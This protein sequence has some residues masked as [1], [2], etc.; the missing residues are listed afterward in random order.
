MYDAIIIG[1]GIGGLTAA[2][3]LAKNGLKVLIL[4]KIHH[5]GG[6]SYIFKRKGYTFPQ[7]PLSFSFP[8]IVQD[9]LRDTGI[10]EKISFERNHFQLIS[11]EIDIVYSQNLRDF[12]EELISRFPA[13][14]EGL[15]KFFNELLSLVEVIADI[16][17]WH[18]DYLIGKE[19]EIAQQKLNSH[20]EQL[21]LVEKYDK[22]SSKDLLDKYLHNQ[23]LKKLL[24]S[25][26]TYEPIMSMV[27]LAFMWNVM[28]QVGI[29]FPSCGI[30]GI[31]DLLSERYRA[32]GGE[33]QL[34]TPVKEILIEQNRVKG[35]RTEGGDIFETSWVIA[36]ADY[37]KV[38]LEMILPT[39]LSATFRESVANTPYTGSE[40]CLYLGIDPK[41]VD[42]SRM[43]ANHLFYRFK[44]EH[45]LKSPEAFEN[46]E[47]EICLW[48]N[49]S[50]EFTPIGQKSLVVRANMPY[51]L[52]DPWRIGEKKRKEGYKA[53][54]EQLADKLISVAEEVLPGL[55]DSVVVQDIATPLTYKDWGQRT[56]GSIAGWGRDIKKVRIHTKLLMKDPIDH[57][58][59]VGI[60]SVLEPFL[61]GFP[62]SMYTGNLA[63][64]FVLET[65][66]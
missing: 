46:K 49:K 65:I 42:L 15:K 51:D 5:I 55:S 56:D 54:K 10:T 27:H 21:Q 50:P 28:S 53:Y 25:Q 64:N 7:G 16:H 60:Y 62:V 61:G 8:S 63:A 34:R 59:V 57:L 43:R 23:S 9:I 14:E 1:A 47:I 52:F 19:R 4:E 66:L 13:E 39:H 41:K 3:K 29:W 6:T 17:Q 33:I 35:V 24:G 31:C 48:S 40:L 30:H 2:A 45:D 38:F 37:K 26:G 18:P 58:L 44:M 11:P 22:I 32:Y 20:K 36:N 12:K